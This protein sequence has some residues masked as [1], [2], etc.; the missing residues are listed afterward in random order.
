MNPSEC[1]NQP[2]QAAP[3]SIS[4]QTEKCCQQPGPNQIA[5]IPGPMMP[6]KGLP[7]MAYP[8]QQGQPPM[9]R[10]PPHQ[11]P[12]PM[13]YPPQQGGFPPMPYAPFPGMM[14]P[15]TNL[16]ELAD[17]TESS[18]ATCT[19]CGLTGMTIVAVKPN[20]WLLILFVICILVPFLV[21]IGLI[22]LF[23]MYNRVHVCSRCQ[24]EITRKRVCC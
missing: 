16:D 9:M 10:Y 2:P 12:P 14:M 15:I 20:I 22:L 1:A 11:G 5:P 13:G 19:K 21:P 4:V 24:N 3:T 8:P 18:L 7:Q 17:R 23:F 6:P